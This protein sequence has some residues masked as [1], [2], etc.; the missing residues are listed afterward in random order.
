MSGKRSNHAPVHD[1]E[2]G[3]RKFTF[4]LKEVTFLATLPVCDIAVKDF[5]C[6]VFL[7]FCL[8]VFLSFCL[9]VC[10]SVKA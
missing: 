8:S 4:P 5:L 2:L 3:K 7:S 6:S 10:L 9:S 1:I